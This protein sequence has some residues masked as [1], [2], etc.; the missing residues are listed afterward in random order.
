MIINL[1]PWPPGV[2]GDK[3]EVESH[4]AQGKKYLQEGQ[5]NEALQH[6][7]SAVGMLPAKAP[8]PCVNGGGFQK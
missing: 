1:I 3:A 5:L 2:L 4:L 6:Y 8:S 7:S